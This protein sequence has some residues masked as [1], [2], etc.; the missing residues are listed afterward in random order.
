MG[1][2]ALRDRAAFT[3]SKLDGNED[4]QLLVVP[5]HPPATA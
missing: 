4:V 5:A 3:P 1:I 2:I